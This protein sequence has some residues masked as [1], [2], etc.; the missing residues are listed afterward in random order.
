VEFK[1]WVKITQTAI[2]LMLAIYILLYCASGQIKP[3][4][5]AYEFHSNPFKAQSLTPIATNVTVF[6]INL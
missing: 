1:P 2:L 4:S 3:R 5:P 6:C